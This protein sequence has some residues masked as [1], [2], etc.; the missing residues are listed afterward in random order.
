MVLKALYEKQED[1]P[2]QFQELYSEKGGKW[3]LTGVEGVKTDADVTRLTTAL[4]YERSEHKRTKEKLS[5][6]AAFGDDPTAI[7]TKLDEIEELRLLTQDKA[8]KAIDELV[9]AR[10]KTRLAPL[11]RERD[12]LKTQVAEKD[13]LIQGF[14]TKEKTRVIH[15]NIK[16]AAT[17]VGLLP[18]AIEDAILFAERVF[19][20][21]DEGKVATKDGLSPDLWLGDLKTSRSHWWGPT[22][23]GGGS[24]GTGGKFA[25]NPWSHSNWSMTEQGKIVREKGMAE[26]EKMAKAAGTTVGGKR[27]QPKK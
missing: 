9:E 26:A 15:D 17:K 22:Q 18:T 11:E 6:W 14:Q 19:D 27:P 10:I 20:V 23:G 7:Q 12:T 25:N 4:N 21:D 8:P 1:I 2:S 5:T 13:G 3:E 16:S 24:G